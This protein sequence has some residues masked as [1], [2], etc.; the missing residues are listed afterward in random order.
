MILLLWIHSYW[1]CTETGVKMRN[2]TVP[3]KVNPHVK[4]T[5]S[6][7]VPMLSSLVLLLHGRTIHHAW[8]TALPSQP[9]CLLRGLT[10][11]FI[12][13]FSH[14][15]CVA[16][17]SD[18][19]ISSDVVPFILKQLFFYSITVTGQI[20]VR[21]RALHVST[22]WGLETDQTIQSRTDSIHFPALCLHYS[23]RLYESTFVW[24]S[25]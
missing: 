15:L 13:C 25:Q 17:H 14:N 8:F 7:A 22:H 21:K 3:H 10:P 9:Y 4:K 1:F 20:A 24:F 5:P 2:W 6:G 18:G 12:Y 23:I 16:K 19:C 11:T